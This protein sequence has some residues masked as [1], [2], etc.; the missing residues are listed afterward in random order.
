MEAEQ[1]ECL[2]FQIFFVI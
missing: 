2:W 1:C